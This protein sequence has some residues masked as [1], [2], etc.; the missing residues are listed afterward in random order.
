M[1]RCA[2]FIRW[3]PSR[4]AAGAALTVGIPSGKRQFMVNSI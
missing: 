3:N 1:T 2:D 4:R